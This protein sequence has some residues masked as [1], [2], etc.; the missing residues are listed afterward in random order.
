MRFAEKCSMQAF[1]L[2]LILP[3]WL[4]PALAQTGG[5][6]LVGAR[7][8]ALGEAFVAVADDGNA[9][10]WN[11]A[12]LTT[13][14]KQEFNSMWADLFGLDGVKNMY[15]SYAL[16]LTKRYSVGVDW[17]HLGFGDDEFSFKQNRYGLSSGYRFFDWFAVGGNLKRFT[18]ETALD[19]QSILDASGLGFDLGL[20]I[21]PLPDL[22][23]GLMAQ[24]VGNTSMNVTS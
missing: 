15:L 7:P 23:L 2:L 11:P 9:A 20:L 5:R 19:G 14:R 22:R 17:L 21:R 16:P 3:V 4:G 24:D 6:L 12:G 1:L 18:M 10:Y 13:L 8:A